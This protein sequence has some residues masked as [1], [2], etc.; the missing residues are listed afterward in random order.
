MSVK[1]V[2][3]R[4]GLRDAS[5]FVRD[6]RRVYGLTPG[7]LRRTVLLEAVAES[8]GGRPPPV[9]GVWATNKANK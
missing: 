1:E 5:H 7:K 6:F 9:T 4:V 2:M 8:T 3:F